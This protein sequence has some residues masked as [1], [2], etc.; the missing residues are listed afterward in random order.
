MSYYIEKLKPIERM[1]WVDIPDEEGATFRWVRATDDE[2]ET[3]LEAQVFATHSSFDKRLSYRVT[4][5]GR[6]WPI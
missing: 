3:V 1:E 2:F 5:G 4:D 6:I